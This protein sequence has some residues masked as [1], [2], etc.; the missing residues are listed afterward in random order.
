MLAERTQNTVADGEVVSMS[1]VKI[2]IIDT[3]LSPAAKCFERVE[4]SFVLKSLNEERYFL[5]EMDFD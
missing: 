3:G 5:E 4:K 2:G 1:N